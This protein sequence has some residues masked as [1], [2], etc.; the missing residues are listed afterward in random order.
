V[1]ED[2]KTNIKLIL[3]ITSAVIITDTLEAIYMYYQ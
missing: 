3:K 1:N 2:W